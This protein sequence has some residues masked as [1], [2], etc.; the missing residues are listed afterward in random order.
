MCVCVCIVYSIYGVCSSI[1]VYVRAFSV[2]VY[3]CVLNS[4][5]W[6]YSITEASSQWSEIIISSEPLPLWA[7]WGSDG[8]ESIWRMMNVVCLMAGH[9]VVNSLEM[10]VQ[11]LWL[12]VFSDCGSGLFHVM[13]KGGWWKHL[14]CVGVDQQSQIEVPPTSIGL[15]L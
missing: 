15:H 12:Q 7:S 3:V 10:T 1:F 11:C 14:T 9:S 6:S 5:S 2:F 4:H 13:A 8:L